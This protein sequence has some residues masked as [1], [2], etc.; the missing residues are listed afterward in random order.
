ML[1]MGVGGFA[2]AGGYGCGDGRI[3]MVRSVF[4]RIEK[5]Q[6]QPCIAA[7]RVLGSV[8]HCFVSPRLMSVKWLR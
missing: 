1:G 6:W 2:S 4:I 5:S 8:G 3:N 7:L